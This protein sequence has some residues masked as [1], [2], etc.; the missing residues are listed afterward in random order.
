MTCSYL[1]HAEFDPS[2]NVYQSLH[3]LFTQYGP[4]VSHS[5]VYLLRSAINALLDYVALHNATAPAA[6]RV[7]HYTDI[8]T[9][10]FTGFISYLRKNKIPVSYADKLKSAMTV[11]YQRTGKLPLIMLP[12]VKVKKDKA[13]E[14]LTDSAYQ[15][16]TTALTMHIGVLRTK[17]EFRKEV[18]SA[19]PYTFKETM[20]EI[21]PARHRGHVFQWYQH[22]LFSG[23][24]T[25]RESMESKF[26]ASGDPELIALCGHKHIAKLFK[27][28]Y[29]REAEPYLLDIPVNPFDTSETGMSFWIPD[30]AR[31][32]KTFLVHG[33]PFSKT[34]EELDAGY[35]RH[36]LHS[37]KDCGDIL[38]LLI[39]RYTTGARHNPEKTPLFDALMEMYYP[40]PLDMTAI[41]TFLMLQSGWNREV[42]LALDGENFEHALTGAISESMRVVFSE[43]N[44]SQ[45][46]NKPYEDPKQITANSDRDNPYSIYSLII[47]AGELSAP[48]RGIPFDNEL[49]LKKGDQMNDLF[50]CLRAWGDWQGNGG[51][52]TSI[53][54]PKA[55][56]TAVKAFFDRYPVYE[57]GRRL[58]VAGDIGRRL[59]PTW[60]KFQ[61][62]TNPLSILSLQMG[63]ESEETT[64][65]FY[66]SSGQAMQERRM[67][68][69]SVLEDVMHLLRTRQ[70]QGLLGEQA[71]LIANTKPR[72]FHIPGMQRAL[73][74][75]RNQ[76]KPSWP[77]SERQIPA[78]QK[79]TAIDKCLGCEQ[80]WITEDSLPFLF[81][82]L[83][84]LE[85]DLEDRDQASYS[86]RLES[87]KEII[88][89]LIDSWDDEDAIRIA[90]R[91]QRKNSPLLPR[92]LASLR[93]IFQEE[94]AN[95]Y[96]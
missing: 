9:E 81:E 64:D 43:K 16:L 57:D 39:H 70:F 33:F 42:V 71:S 25:S 14:P 8:S 56:Q 74:G 45:A 27:E 67:K 95:D 73:W 17:L 34:L 79:C 46:L 88:E 6:L 21:F 28:I 89:Y 1:D 5:S 3:Y 40:T 44:K 47:L 87:E 83:Q 60:A 19:I 24:K 68:L 13:T 49:T 76:G 69:R 55:Y 36:V 84:H 80:V 53:T 58:A 20:D 52:H 78:G 35:N 12:S 82:R 66:D 15:E 11:V 7:T 31:T 63:H 22:I 26:L 37:V 18:E 30:T 86:A 29:Q 41:V 92:D 62:K 4:N 32:L 94:N 61:R 85:E 48:L 75:C 51:R 38:Q 2:K 96:A 72:F 23:V 54:N 59:R 77:G 90:E 91:Y 65:I 93:L 50:L 10:L